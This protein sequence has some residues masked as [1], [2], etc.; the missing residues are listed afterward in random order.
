MTMKSSMDTPQIAEA[1][2][3]GVNTFLETVPPLMKALDEV[4]KTHTFISGTGSFFAVNAEIPNG[5]FPRQVTV[6]AFRAAYTLEKKRREN[7]KRVLAI[8][9]EYV[10]LDH[11]LSPL[12]H[13]FQNERDD[14]DPRPVRFT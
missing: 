12:F 9:N 8:Y 10:A 5:D 13:R 1:I 3:K 2:Q 7:D 4:A 11:T 14:D 6:I